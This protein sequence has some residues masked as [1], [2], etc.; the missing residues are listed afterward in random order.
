[1][2][3]GNKP[4]PSP[5]LTQ[6]YVDIGHSEFARRFP[7]EWF[8]VQTCLMMTSSNGNI[9]RVTDPLCGEFTGHRRIPHTKTSDVE[10]WSF[11]WSAF[12]IN[13]WVNNRK[14]GDLR[15]HRG[16]HDV[17]VM[18]LSKLPTG[19]H[20]WSSHVF[21]IRNRILIGFKSTS[22]VILSL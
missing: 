10:L 11:L 20:V 22:F 12:W 13:G 5:M 16:H 21:I 2:P 1:M 3:S 17:I 7:T 6:I 8:S 18:T 15:C 9:S 4:L 14:A 19:R